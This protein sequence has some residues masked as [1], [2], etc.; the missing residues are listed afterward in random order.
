MISGSMSPSEHGQVD[1]GPHRLHTNCPNTVDDQQ[2]AVDV[3]LDGCQSE[4][5][6]EFYGLIDRMVIEMVLEVEF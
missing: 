6:A 3:D 4:N 5:L 1:P 2:H